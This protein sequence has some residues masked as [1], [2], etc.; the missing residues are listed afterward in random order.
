MFRA[1]TAHALGRAKPPTAKSAARDA[2]SPPWKTL[3]QPNG[4]TKPPKPKRTGIKQTPVGQQGRQRLPRVP[5]AKKVFAD[6]LIRTGRRPGY[7]S[8]LSSELNRV[9]PCSLRRQPS[10]YLHCVRDRLPR[11]WPASFM[12][13]SF[14]HDPPFPGTR[15]ARSEPPPILNGFFVGPA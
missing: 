5:G 6:A 2:T 3:P 11:S 10:G 14:L 4:H 13:C 7:S 15:L 9:R 12:G 1:M 8:R